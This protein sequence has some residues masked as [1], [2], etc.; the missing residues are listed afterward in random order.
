MICCSRLGDRISFS[1]FFYIMTRKDKKDYSGNMADAATEGNPG[2]DTLGSA[3]EF[4][5]SSKIISLEQGQM[6]NLPPEIE[7]LND[8]IKQR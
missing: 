7:K 8:D 3:K 4:T 5:H 1:E 6:L 2:P